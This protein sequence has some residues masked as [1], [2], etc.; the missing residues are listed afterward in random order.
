VF[1]G[2]SVSFDAGLLLGLGLFTPLEVALLET[3]VDTDG[4][5]VRD[6]SGESDDF[7]N[8]N[9]SKGSSDDIRWETEE[10]LGN[11]VNTR[12][13]IVE[14]R[15][16]G[17]GFTA[18]VDLEV[19]RTL[20][21]NG[22][23]AL[24]QGVADEASTVLLNEP[25]LHLTVNEEQELG[26]SGVS[27]WGVHS[28]RC[29]LT[30]SQG[31]AVREKGREIRDVGDGEVPTGIPGGSN[32]SI[33]IEQPLIQVR[34]SAARS[35]DGSRSNTH[36]FV[37]LENVEASDLGRCPLQVRHEV[38]GFDGVCGLSDSLENS[39]EDERDSGGELHDA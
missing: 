32:S 11:L 10:S 13:L 15:D 4:Q 7:L 17:D 26:R 22:P 34:R 27:V 2:E 8:T 5:V 28:A 35:R 33:I 16:E 1:S 9:I 31:H 25:D 24:G 29:H 36:I 30:D 12:I 14:S 18:E 20:G 39:S 21:E 38:G 19:D 23:L 37:V 3:P 6:T